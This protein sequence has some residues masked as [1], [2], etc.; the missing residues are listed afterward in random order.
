MDRIRSTNGGENR[1]AHKLFVGKLEGKK[2][3]GRPKHR[4]VD[5]I[6]MDL[7]ELY[8]GVIWTELMWLGI[9]T[10]AGLL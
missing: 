1:N 7:R 2:V 3:L 6:K 4:L 10:S 5:F 8:I 9:G